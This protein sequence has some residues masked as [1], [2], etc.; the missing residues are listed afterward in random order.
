M[1]VDKSY[2]ILSI[3]EYFPSKENPSTSTWV[4]NQ[5]SGI[6]ENGIEPLI[7]SPTPYYPNFLNKF[8]NNKRLLKTKPNSSI[9]EYN[10]VKVIRPPYIKLPNEYFLHSNLSRFSKASI[11]ATKDFTFKAIHAHFGHAGVA[12]IKL[13]QNRKIPLI[14]SFYGYDLGSDK[15]PLL[16]KYKELAN[17]GDLFLA[18]SMDMH[19]DLAELGFPESKILIH[20][21]GVNFAQFFPKSPTIINKEAPFTFLIVASFEERKG[22]HIAIE[23]FKWISRNDTTKNIQLKIVGDGPYKNNLL[24]LANGFNNIVF[25]NNFTASNP[26]AFVQQEMQNC[27]VF[28]L[29]SITLDN[30]EKEGTPVVLMEAQACGKPCI[31]TFHAGIPEVVVHNETG[32][33]V[34]EKSVSELVDTMSLFIN[35]NAL[36]FEMGDKAYKHIRLNFN[37]QTQN[38][39]LS[40]LYLSIIK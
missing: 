6:Q 36:V 31:S 20:H 34:K 38:K 22:I 30:G 19:K 32:F 3:R 8:Y 33:L 14:T 5:A 7:V 16:R 29:P 10:G 39:I 26:R 35:N 2:D 4:F 13:K 40:D 37:N 1:I 11:L 24:A 12:S 15:L 28:M 17:S 9:E 21:L 18:L 27:D 25:V 23:A